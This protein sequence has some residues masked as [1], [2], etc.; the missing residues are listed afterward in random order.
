MQY[1][2]LNDK[3]APL[4]DIIRQVFFDIKYF[5]VVLFIMINVFATAF[6]LLGKNQAQNLQ[7]IDEPKQVA[8]NSEQ[9]E[10]D[11]AIVKGAIEGKIKMEE[12]PY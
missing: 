8:S 3:I 9:K 6:M 11:K 1:L 4:I 10:I 5:S 2:K 7:P 12:V